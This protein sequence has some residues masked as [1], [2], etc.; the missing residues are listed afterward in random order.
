VS[1]TNNPKVSFTMT[2]N[3]VLTATFAPNPFPA[4][5]GSYRGIFLNQD[6]N[7]FRPENAGFFRLHL[8]SQGSFSGK[9]TMQEGDY[10]FRGKFDWMGNAQ[11][12][13]VRRT[14][15]PVVFAL[16]LDLANGIG[17][18]SGTATTS[19]SGGLLTSDLIA[20]R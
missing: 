11:V 9:V 1:P 19:S 4:V 3:L 20:F 18:L 8:A 2:S 17:L 16:Q 15:P 12:S 13:I 5:A 7:F 14:F 10:A 6:P